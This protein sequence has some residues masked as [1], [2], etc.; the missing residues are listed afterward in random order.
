MKLENSNVI[1]LSVAHSGANYRIHSTGTT[2]PLAQQ[3]SVVA[4]TT[5]HWLVTN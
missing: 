5:K 2:V 3:Q 4:V 1:I